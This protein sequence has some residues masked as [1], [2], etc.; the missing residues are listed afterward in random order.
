MLGISTVPHTVI[1][2]RFIEVIFSKGLIFSDEILVVLT[3]GA[4]GPVLPH[5]GKLIFGVMAVYCTN[6]T[7]AEY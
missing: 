2:I 3:A 1:L 6:L 7:F 5:G 4:G